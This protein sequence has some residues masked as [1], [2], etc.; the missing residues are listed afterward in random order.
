MIG[1]ASGPDRG[2]RDHSEV[3]IRFDRVSMMF[4][5]RAALREVSLDVYRGEI[6]ALLGPNGAGKSTIFALIL[7]HLGAS[8]GDIVVNGTSVSCR[9][10]RS[11]CSTSPQRA[12]IPRASAT[13]AG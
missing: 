12:S 6:L 13:C 3:I 5:H 11:C 10:P 7:G 2:R 4:R 1:R 9:P 8:A